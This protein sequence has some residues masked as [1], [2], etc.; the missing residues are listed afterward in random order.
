M[1]QNYCNIFV[2][3]V[4]ILLYG[5]IITYIIKNAMAFLWFIGGSL[6]ICMAFYYPELSSYF[7]GH[8]EDDRKEQEQ[9]K[10]PSS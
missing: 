9:E 4:V 10:Q 8:Q 6:I 3:L 2:L 5:V 7:K 1:S